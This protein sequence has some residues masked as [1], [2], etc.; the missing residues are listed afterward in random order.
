MSKHLSEAIRVPIEGDN[1]SIRRIENLCI[2]CGQCRDICRDYV[3]VL[4]YYDLAKT[5]DTAVCI[6]CG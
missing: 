4:G 2:K 1:P 3:S 5:N 6:H